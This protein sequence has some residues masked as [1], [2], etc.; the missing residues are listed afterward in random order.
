MF[1]NIS[2]KI[3][4]CVRILQLEICSNCSYQD[5]FKYIF[6]LSVRVSVCHMCSGV[7]EAKGSCQVS[8]SWICRWLCAPW[9]GCMKRRFSWREHVPLMGSNLPRFIVRISFSSTLKHQQHVCLTTSNWWSICRLKNC[10]HLG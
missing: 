5:T 3:H 7:E 1:F 10:L 2:Y 8:W 4:C 9:Y 6:L